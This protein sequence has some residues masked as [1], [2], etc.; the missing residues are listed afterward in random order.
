MDLTCELWFYISK[1]FADY[2]IFGRKRCALKPAGPI[3]FGIILGMS[4]VEKGEKPVKF[5]PVN[6]GTKFCHIEK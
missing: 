3:I 6:Y 1:I 4:K 5:N 2:R